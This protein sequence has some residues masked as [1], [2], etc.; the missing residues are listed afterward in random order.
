VE[1][2]LEGMLAIVGLGL[3]VGHTDNM[4]LTHPPVG[5]TILECVISTHLPADNRLVSCALQIAGGGSGLV[6]S[7]QHKHASQA[8]AHHQN[9]RDTEEQYTFLSGNHSK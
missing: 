6:A 9:Y 8:Q 4:P 5:P 3:T 1:N 7:D 2:N